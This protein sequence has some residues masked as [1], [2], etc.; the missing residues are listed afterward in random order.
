MRCFVD[1]SSLASTQEPATPNLKLPR[2][3]L[4]PTRRVVLSFI[5]APLTNSSAAIG[6]LR[7]LH[8]EPSR[9]LT[10]PTQ[11]IGRI[12]PLRPSGA[13]SPSASG[14]TKTDLGRA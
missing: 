12:L 7:K 6:H 13:T 10:L 3:A 11:L 4:T 2:T 9:K 14:A 5:L 1:Y 8:G